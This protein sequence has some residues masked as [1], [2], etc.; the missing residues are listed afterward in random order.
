MLPG[1]TSRW[2]RPLR[3]TASR[4]SA[5]W[6]PISTTCRHGSGPDAASRSPRFGPVDQL[7]G[8]VHVVALAAVGEHPHDRRVLHVGEHLGLAGEAA[9]QLRVARAQQLDRHD[10]PQLLVARRGDHGPAAGADVLEH[11]EAVPEARPGLH[12]PA[13]EL[14][15]PAL[16]AGDNG[17]SLLVHVRR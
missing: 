16:Q 6:I 17:G 12:P 8:H 9:L 3:W 11:D 4:A 7:E 2:M 1:F 13:F 5:I 10:G 15:R 14:R